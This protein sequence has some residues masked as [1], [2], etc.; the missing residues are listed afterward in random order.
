MAGDAE[1][2][3]LGMMELTSAPIGGEYESF[4]QGAGGDYDT[5]P[6]ATGAGCDHLVAGVDYTLFS[7]DAGEYAGIW[8]FDG[9]V[10]SKSGESGNTYRGYH[11]D[12]AADT[13][14]ET[15]G[16]SFDRQSGEEIQFYFVNT[17]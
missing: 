14:L 11:Q 3:Q 15:A 4:K 2:V 13:Q 6:T 16:A 10:E 7:C 17:L 5:L 1:Y 8:W 9:N 12:T